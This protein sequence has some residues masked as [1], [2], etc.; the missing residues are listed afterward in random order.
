MHPVFHISQLKQHVGQA[1]VQTALPVLDADG[2]ISHEPVQ[3][4]ERRISKKGNRAA[5]Q[6]LVKWS[7][8]YPEDATWEFL[9]DLQAKFPH[10]DP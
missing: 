1:E 10:F 7:D 3:I 2:L 4:L 6:V 8:S 9:L 5:T